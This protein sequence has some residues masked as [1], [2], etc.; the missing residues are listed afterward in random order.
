MFYCVE[1]WKWW[2]AVA[3]LQDEDSGSSG[4]DVSG[5]WWG[6]DRRDLVQ[7]S[8]WLRLRLDW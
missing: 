4:G 6:R 5:R 3:D 1:W 7:G 8:S 2:W